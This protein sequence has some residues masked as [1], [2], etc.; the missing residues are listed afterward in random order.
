MGSTGGP[1][2]SCSAQ[3][4]NDALHKALNNAGGGHGAALLEL[5]HRY[6]EASLRPRPPPAF[7]PPDPLP[8]ADV[9][10]PKRVCG[11]G[12][13]VEAKQQLATSEACRTLFRRPERRLRSFDVVYSCDGLPQVIPL[14]RPSGCADTPISESIPPHPPPPSSSGSDP[15]PAP[16]ASGAS[17]S[18]EEAVPAAGNSARS[19]A[20]LLIAQRDACALG[21]PMPSATANDRPSVATTLP[22]GGLAAVAPLRLEHRSPKWSAGRPPDQPPWHDHLPW[23]DGPQLACHI[24]GFP[25]CRKTAEAKGPGPPLALSSVV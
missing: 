1:L 2:R 25:P 7:A 12:P 19:C 3:T 9:P 24:L 11:A 14:L 13:S 6:A 17:G 15:L 22:A 5:M 8:D 21:S 16:A 18:P 4:Q 20:P 10:P 23:P